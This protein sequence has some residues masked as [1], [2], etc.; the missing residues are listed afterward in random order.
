MNIDNSY[1]SY[2]AQ[3][4][5][6]TENFVGLRKHQIP[7]NLKPLQRFHKA[8]EKTIIK[9]SKKKQ[10][11]IIMSYL[12]KVLITN[13]SMSELHIVFPVTGKTKL[14]CF[15][16]IKWSMRKTHSLVNSSQI[17][18]RLFLSESGSLRG[19]SSFSVLAIRSDQW[20][21]WKI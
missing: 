5:Q 15:K 12:Y 3:L 11:S 18:S 2:I 17:A 10:N 9:N 19:F 13:I 16:T 20:N 6:V 8:L 14:T 4:I 21:D 1:Y 7:V